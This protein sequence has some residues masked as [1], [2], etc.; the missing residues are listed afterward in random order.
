MSSLKGY[1][2]IFFLFVSCFTPEST[3]S[4]EGAGTPLI[5]LAEMLASEHDDNRYWESRTKT[6]SSGIEQNTGASAIIN[7]VYLHRSFFWF[8]VF[9]L[10][11]FFIC[12]NILWFAAFYLH[13]SDIAKKYKRPVW[14]IST[15]YVTQHKDKWYNIFTKRQKCLISHRPFIYGFHQLL[16][17]KKYFQNFS[18]HSQNYNETQVRDRNLSSWT[19]EGPHP[20]EVSQSVDRHCVHTATLLF[21]NRP[22]HNTWKHKDTRARVSQCEQETDCL[23]YIGLV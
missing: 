11:V 4:N 21:W 6:H 13:F 3:T 1:V 19:T 14:D 10:F 20:S 16:K 23:L 5:S 15:E 9:F 22:D 18:C 12:S 8:G 7:S 2:N 17:K